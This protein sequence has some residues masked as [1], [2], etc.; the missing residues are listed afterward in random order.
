M[1]LISEYICVERIWGSDDLKKIFDCRTDRIIG[2]VWTLSGYPEYETYLFDADGRR[3]GRLD[4]MTEEVVGARMPRFPI[5]MKIIKANSWLSIQVH[6]DDEYARKVENEPWGKN[7]MWY[8]LDAEE[9]AKLVNGVN[10]RTKE[11]FLKALSENELEGYL[12]FVEVKE[13]DLIDIRSGKVHTLGPG[14]LILEIQQTSD[15]TYRIYDWG[16]GREL[17]IKKA[18]DVL[19]FDD[20]LARVM[21][22]QDDFENRYFRLRKLKG[23]NFSHGFSILVPLMDSRVDGKE[24]GKYTNVVIPEGERARLN[25]EFIEIKLGDFYEIFF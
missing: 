24:V 16:R 15:L 7:E 9:G 12:N 18:L 21:K 2:E 17:H 4:E 1:F 10:L 5:L 19:N 23:E 22:F 11:D 20:P 14:I 25:G 8:V 13:G 6:P 3:V